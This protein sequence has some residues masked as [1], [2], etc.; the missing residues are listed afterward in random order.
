MSLVT[1]L[2]LGVAAI[3]T[4]AVATGYVPLR[5]PSTGAPL[6]WNDG[7]NIVVV[8][9]SS[10]SDDLLSYE[11][12]PALRLALE[13]WN[14]VPG[15]YARFLENTNPA[16]RARTDWQAD[17]IHLLLFDEDNSS[18]YFPLGS[19][20]VAITPVWFQSN[21]RIV[22][23]DILFNGAGYTF[24]TDAGSGN[25]DVMDV[26]VHEL[27]HML[28]FDHSPVVGSSLFPYVSPGLVLHRSLA[29]DDELA[30]RV[31]YPQVTRARIKGRIVHGD[32]SPVA[33]A[34]VVARDA[35]GR[36]VGAAL[37]NA[38][39]NFTLPGLE[40]GDV[41][42]FAVPLD[43]PVTAANFSGA[44]SVDTGFAATSV[45]S[46]T[47]PASGDVLLGDLTV[48]PD[49]TLVLGR[50]FDP[51]PLRATSGATTT[52]VVRGVGLDPGSTL[53]APDPDVDVAVLGWFASSV[54]F[55]VTVPAGEEPGLV[56]LE[57]VDASGD[58]A[59][60]AGALEIVPPDPVVSTVVPGTASSQGGTQVTLVGTGFRSGASVVVGGMVL[61]DGKDCTVVDASTI[62]FE[63]PVCPPATYDV[64]VI[65][66]TGVEGR[67][68]GGLAV[69]GDPVI[70]SVFPPAGAALGGTEVV[71]DGSGFDPGLTVTIDGVSQPVVDVDPDRVVFVT[72]SA[73]P[74]GYALAVTNPIGSADTASF[75]YAP[76]PDPRIDAVAP[77]KGP[78][79]GGTWVTVTGAALRGD[80]EVIFGADPDTGAGGHAAR[81]VSLVDSNS[82]MALSPPG[83]GSA[84]VVL[85][86]PTTQQASAL[87]AAFAY[88][89]PPSSSGGG[90]GSLVDPRAPG[91]EWMAG[92]WWAA[93]LL[94]V[95]LWRATRATGRLAALDAP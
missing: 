58:R 13:A 28:G 67:K 81:A 18:G 73:L 55:Q 8:L 23:A 61:R 80:L 63:L 50:S 25:F 64:V 19:S 2:A 14:Q 17:D 68:V 34:H 42:L 84:S 54:S 53:T 71:L 36:T 51:L 52:H 39:G 29:S 79:A 48:D 74:G 86:D 15:S 11:H 88:T 41:E 62:E 69:G 44:P 90:C 40:A 77:S 30:V 82:L 93:L 9:S 20:T 87:P 66:P 4:A 91:A 1:R 5:H 78:A 76:T 26:A 45:A 95:C 35:D 21:G 85:R 70:D 32:L 27:G 38:T 43:G 47:L 75:S 65:D 49:T 22:D 60:L 7:G 46:I 37:A 57:V 12:E 31:R 92:L 33:R 16:Q 94:V 83:S 59:L 6:F 10:G 89:A 3:A 24:S 72:Q 56:D